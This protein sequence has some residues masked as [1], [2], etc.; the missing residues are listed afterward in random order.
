MRY[1]ELKQ[2]EVINICDGKR[3]GGIVDL[4]IECET[5]RLLAIVV[6]TPF[7]LA[8]VFRG[9][10]SGHVIPWA[11]VVKI[12]DDAVLVQVDAIWATHPG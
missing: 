3:L 4:E 6:P 1:S 10:P 5:G 11:S 12:G 2:K 9:D 7:S 8:A